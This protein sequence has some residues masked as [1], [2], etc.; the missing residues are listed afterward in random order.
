[1]RKTKFQRVTAFVLA[2]VFLFTGALSIGVSAADSGSGGQ[3]GANQKYNALTY[4]EYAAQS[5]DVPRADKEV[6]LYDA[7]TA[8]GYLFTPDGVNYYNE[9]GFVYNVN[10]TAAADPYANDPT[11]DKLAGV[12]EYDG[13]NGL[14]IPGTGTIT[15]TTEDV[16]KTAKYSILIEYY[17]VKNLSNPIERRF[18]L[19]G[20]V[21]FS[22]AR[23]LTIAKRWSNVYSDGAFLLPEGESAD[24]YMA[25][26]AQ[27]GITAYTENRE[28]GVYIVYK[29]PEYWTKDISS[30]VDEQTVRFFTPDI[31][32][33]EIRASLVQAPE[34][35]TYE[36]KDSNGFYQS[37]FEFVVTPENGQVSI[38]LEGVNEPIAIKSVKLVVPKDSVSYADYIKKYENAP[39]GTDQIKIEAEYF[40]A[41]SS[42]TVYPIEDKSSAITSPSATDRTVLN[43]IGG[44]K[45]QTVGQWVTYQFEV[46]SSGLYE[47]AARYR[48]ALLDGMF[49][50]RAL[51]LYSDSTVNEGEDGYYN[52]LPFA[53]AANLRFGYSSDWQSE[54]VNDGQEGHLDGFKFYFKEGVVYTLKIEVSLGSM[55]DIVNTVQNSL[56]SINND[57]LSFIKLTGSSPDEYRDYGFNR[58]M[59]DT[60]IDLIIQARTLEEVSSN[61]AEI[62]GD[63]SSM[64]ATLAD[65]ARLLN[66]MGTDEDEVAKSLEELKT[67]IGSLGTWLGDAKTQP[68]VLDFISVQGESYDLPKAKANFWQS[69]VY[70]LSRF[71]MSFFRN[72]DRMGT[73]KMVDEDESVEVWLSSGRDQS[74]VV[75]GLINNDFSRNTGIPVDLKLIAAGTLL[76]SILAG[77]GPDVY[78]GLVQ[79]DVINYAIRGALLPVDG[80][81]GFDGAITQF[82][83]AAMLVLGIE[84][85]KG[86]Y[87]YYG[88]PEAQAFNMMFIRD[89]ILADLGLK[90]PE[91]WDDLLEAIPV[92]QA[93]NMMIGMHTDYKVFL[94]QMDG[95]LF[96]DNGMRINLD[97]NLALEAFNTMC[98]MFTMYSFPYKYDPANRFRTGEMPILFAEYAA[99]YNQLKVFATE[100]EGLW[101]FHPMPGYMDENGKLNNVSVSN[102]SAI[103]MITDCKDEASAWEFM[104]WHSGAQCQSDYSNE[105]IALI[106]PSAKR[107][108]ANINALTSMG[109]TAT[110]LDAL[111]TQFNNLASIPN[112]PGSYI[113]DRY[114]NFAFLAAYNNGADP[115]TEL[116]SYITTINKEITRKRSEFEL[117]TLDYIGQTLAEKRMGQAT[118]ALAA[119]KESAS[120]SA[121][122]NGVYE[123]AIAAIDEGK[124]EDYAS[125]RSAAIA[126]GEANAELFADAIKYLNSAA[127]ALESY[128]AYK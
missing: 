19:N 15:W 27:I 33:N 114:T 70:E 102:L 120:Y 72:Y 89:D 45:W 10:N 29:M 59:P 17:P 110:E 21:P 58:I 90:V 115:V 79:G 16:L 99:T 126:L 68:L 84:N 60:M 85:S 121:S 24:T 123:R 56:D 49:V 100:I 30:L 23:Y 71:F 92:L 112:Y 47:I 13:K 2:L 9:D 127:T 38:S 81:E 18:T 97:S 124:T 119:A 128:E 52:G 39:E 63:K 122:Y 103:V 101:S 5:A 51:Y 66:K 1:M 7:E 105:M 106:G 64:T 57:Y 4:K 55:G 37:A 48:Q 98:N 91:T 3:S 62:A 87:H 88:L 107:A 67:D 41:S 26:A 104:K 14:Y 78:I 32:K 43:T 125:L 40:S 28:D 111:L 44:E 34:W 46:S 80:C 50:S 93:N 75:R 116:Q 12:R 77:K 96:A 6:V 69:M 20:S 11:S 86:E 117:E 22:E 95:E 73:M 35:N 76:P 53:E 82:N 25:K 42:Q 8:T 54:A 74:Q 94:Y 31:D 83:E 109:W 118:D 113:I 108:T 36:F 65:I 61:L